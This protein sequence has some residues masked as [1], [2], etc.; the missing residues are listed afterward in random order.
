MSGSCRPVTNESRIDWSLKIE[1]GLIR[2]PSAVMRGT[3]KDGP[4]VRPN[5]NEKLVQVFDT[6]QESEALVVH[7]LLESSGIDSDIT[8]LDARPDIVPES[9]TVILV[10][11]EVR[12]G[13]ARD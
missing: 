10:H 1:A 11:K 12:P 2:N 5:P 3:M 7:G 6:E 4:A 13:P 9:E 8:S